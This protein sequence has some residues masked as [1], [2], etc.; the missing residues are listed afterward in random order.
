MFNSSSNTLSSNKTKSNKA[1]PG[2]STPMK[3]T[4]D[5]VRRRGRWMLAVVAV[6]VA[7]AAANINTSNQD[8]DIVRTTPIS[9]SSSSSPPRV[10]VI[11]NLYEDSIDGD[12]MTEGPTTCN[13]RAAAFEAF[14]ERD[15]GNVILSSGRH[16]ML[17]QAR[18][19]GG[20]AVLWQLVAVVAALFSAFSFCH[21][22]A[23][24]RSTQLLRI[25]LTGT[26]CVVALL[27]LYVELIQQAMASTCTGVCAN[28]AKGKYAIG[29]FK[30][31]PCPKGYY[32][33]SKGLKSSTCSGKCAAGYYGSST[34]RTSSTCSGKCAAGYYGSS[35]SVRSSST[36]TG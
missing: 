23:L 10:D 18:G 34:G 31:N 30:C 16:H 3:A 17:D 33:S 36:C 15:D 13:L 35:T 5:G 6:A 26:I 32:G 28:C 20:A 2:L 4:S 12:C 9:S 7:V 21:M 8:D 27:F 19:V 14:A 29:A 11:A 24:G 22:V 25:K 1:P